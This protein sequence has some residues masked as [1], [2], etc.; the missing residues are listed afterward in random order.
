MFD[1]VW[2]FMLFFN[3]GTTI[4][5]AKVKECVCVRLSKVKDCGYCHCCWM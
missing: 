2:L 5:G 4:K 1:F 3:A